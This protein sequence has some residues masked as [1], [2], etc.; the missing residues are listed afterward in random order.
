MAGFAC[1]KIVSWVV[2]LLLIV[3]FLSIL[4]A[5]QKIDSVSIAAESG[6]ATVYKEERAVCR[7]ASSPQG[8]PI[9]YLFS[10]IAK[11]GIRFDESSSTGVFDCTGKCSEGDNVSCAAF[12]SAKVPAAPAPCESVC[13]LDAYL[14]CDGQQTPSFL[15]SLFLP[16][17]DSCSFTKASRSKVVSATETKLHDI[18]CVRQDPAS[19]SSKFII[20]ECAGD[21][22]PI[23][24]ADFVTT[25]ASERLGLRYETLVQAADEPKKVLAS[26]ILNPSAGAVSA[27]VLPEWNG[28][29]GVQRRFFHYFKDA[30]NEIYLDK[31]L[32]G[33]VQCVYTTAGAI[34]SAKVPAGSWIRGSQ[35]RLLMQWNVT[36]GY[37][38]CSADDAAQSVSLTKPIVLDASPQLSVGGSFNGGIKARSRFN[39]QVWRA[40]FPTTAYCAADETWAT[41]LDSK[42]KASCTASKLSWTGTACCGEFNDR[43]EFYNEPIP[44]DASTPGACWNSTFISNGNLVKGAGSKV[45]A[46]IGRLFGCG[47]PQSDPLLS[48]KDA[49]KPSLPLI[50]PVDACALAHDI[51]GQPNFNLYCS[52]KTLDWVTAP[53]NKDLKLSANP[54]DPNDKDCCI[55]GDSCWDGKACVHDQTNEAAL[56]ITRG[57]RCING[58]WIEAVNK[59]TSDRSGRGFC[60]QKADCLVNPGGNPLNNYLPDKCFGPNAPVSARPQCSLD[61]PACLS[62]RQYFMDDLCLDGN[63]TSRTKSIA[64]ELLDLASTQSPYDYALFC[65]EYNDV[66][67][68]ISDSSLGAVSIRDYLGQTCSKG[69]MGI[70]CVNNFCALRYSGNKVA[71][72]TSINVP[73][74]DAGKSFL[75]AIGLTEH[76][77]DNAAADDGVFHSCTASVSYNHAMQAVVIK[78]SASSQVT[79][80]VIAPPVNRPSLKRAQEL[81]LNAYLG[82]IRQFFDKPATKVFKDPLINSTRFDNLFIMKK[83]DRQYF[84]FLE[85]DVSFSFDNQDVPFSE[86]VDVASIMY[87]G[88][89]ISDPVTGRQACDLI[90]DRIDPLKTHPLGDRYVC[91]YNANRLH[92]A[93][94]EKTAASGATD[95]PIRRFWRDMTSKLR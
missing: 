81:V 45:L 38:N 19:D 12:A 88:I 54:T 70:P 18:A 2:Y 14:S 83:S 42:G 64:L 37:L 23:T 79:G 49:H 86:V 33:S 73:I 65:G 95:F 87:D 91:D 43:P 27:D 13:S 92:M 85:K 51:N 52:P 21:D 67:N 75:K 50:Q 71:F 93:A 90:N 30:D 56:K 32:D 16:V 24:G 8:T 47:I 9:S 31:S 46:A 41:S 78:P 58:Q 62:D 48:L 40:P 10:R 15:S 69:G 17:V 77:C 80:G 25:G 55:A 20:R 28:N 82:D 11:S 89:T 66:L 74:D 53:S 39:I 35:H 60:P 68:V 6:G 5:A 22:E 36:A 63:W 4:V 59:L 84:G 1:W 3:I 29:D 76:A 57:F 72:G 94:I 44:F 26:L 61:G 34:A 7:G